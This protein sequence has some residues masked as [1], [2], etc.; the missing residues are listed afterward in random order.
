MMEKTLVEQ[1]SE[2]RV[3]PQ[4]R[5]FRGFVYDFFKRFADIVI[6]LF[7]CLFLIPFIPIVFAVNLCCKDV[8]S[9]FYRQ[10]RVGKNGKIFYLY[11]FRSM[12]RNAD[13]VLSTYLAENPEARAEYEEF[14]KLKDDPRITKN[15]KFLRATSLDEL[16]QFINVLFGTMSF[17][18]PRPYFAW[19]LE[20]SK[21]RDVILSVRP[22]LTGYWQVN[23]RSNVG[24]DERMQMEADYVRRRSLW[25]DVKIFFKTF[26]AVFEKNGAE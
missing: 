19:E 16:P 9:V 12:V 17:I 25:L 26:R 15:G 18:G 5:S 4:K 21:E 7:G 1:Q 23:G 2:T 20:Q 13:A 11:K 8:G 6:G 22:G 10:K 3:L 14:H 24:Y